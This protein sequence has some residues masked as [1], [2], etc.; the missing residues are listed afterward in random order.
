M[1]FLG[2][3]ENLVADIILVVLAIF[4]GWL[5]ITLTQR[6]KLLQFFGVSETK[7]LN[8]YLSNLR[9]MVFGAIG[10]TGKKMSYEG[11]SVPY[12]EMEVA[13]KIQ[14]LF[15]F[16]IPALAEAS[17]A[18]GKLFLSDV[19]AQI[20]VSPETISTID[21]QA[22]IVALGSPA[23]NTAA[24]YIEKNKWGIVNYKLG[25]I[26]ESEFR[27]IKH[28]ARPILK[29]SSDPQSYDTTSTTVV[30]TAVTSE[31]NPILSGSAGSPYHYDY[32][33]EF[34]TVEDEDDPAEEV[35]SKEESAILVNGIPPIT[36]TT[37]GIIERIIIQK[38]RFLFYISGLSEFATKNAAKYLISQWSNLYKKY[39]KDKSFLILLKFDFSDSSKS[40]VV[41][42]KEL[43]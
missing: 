41:F 43:P 34:H 14:R 6:K 10:T 13:I 17:N 2:V 3:L 12:G 8:I 35:N 27:K 7:R 38:D 9:V 19:S 26:T 1:F 4:A 29:S 37:Q 25:T 28:S 15:A 11:T 21:T 36:D 33:D 31:I 39:G 24:L 5:W 42:E 22:T 16:I 30:G 32:L 18:I 40:S 20:N 23:Y